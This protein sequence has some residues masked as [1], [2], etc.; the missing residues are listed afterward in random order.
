MLSEQR[1]RSLE[2]K[3][4]ASISGVRKL[5][6]ALEA[7]PAKLTSDTVS[8]DSVKTVVSTHDR[9][10]RALSS[11]S[12][13]EFQF[14]HREFGDTVRLPIFGVILLIFGEWTP[15][16][17]LIFGNIV[18]KTCHIPRQVE[19]ALR[20]RHEARDER[21]E[22]L[23]ARSV[24][25][26]AVKETPRAAVAEVKRQ[27]SAQQ[28]KRE[29]D[30]QSITYG[31]SYRL[32]TY[33]QM[34]DLFGLTS[35]R[36]TRRLAYLDADDAL[37]LRDGG[38]KR[39]AKIIGELSRAELRIACDERGIEVL[40]KTGQRDDKGKKIWEDVPVERL[41]EQLR[42]WLHVGGWRDVLISPESATQIPKKKK[43]V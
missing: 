7:R 27:Q 41:R 30:P 22:R 34:M 31:L 39:I 6:A 21:L 24:P 29:V 19:S 37:L 14:L 5:G 35:R 25:T 3:N 36:L 16:L 11:L 23:S 13:A 18:P 20:K 2:A 32:G 10:T 1:T 12:R 43:H 15:A 28:T 26:T 9:G 17:V 38:E 40:R 4:Q 42:D 33:S 8:A